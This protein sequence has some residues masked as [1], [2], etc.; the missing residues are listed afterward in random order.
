VNRLIQKG[1][2]PH[3]ILVL[4]RNGYETETIV[5][6]LC[7]RGS[8]RAVPANSAASG[9]QVRVSSLDAATGLEAP[10]VVIMELRMVLEGEGNPMLGSERDQLILDNSRKIYMAFTRAGYRLLLIWSGESPA[11]FAVTIDR[12]N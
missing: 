5:A 12:A 11:P 10:Y 1:A 8:W 9:N 7:A 4:H 6:A 3:D 2:P